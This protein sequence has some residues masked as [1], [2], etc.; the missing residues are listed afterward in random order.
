MI[1][2]YRCRYL[3]ARL[4]KRPLNSSDPAKGCYYSI[5]RL[6]KGASLAKDLVKITGSINARFIKVQIPHTNTSH[7]VFTSQISSPLS[8]RLPF[9][10]PHPSE[11]RGV[12]GELILSDLSAT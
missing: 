7:R 9:L 2:R 3:T 1:K 8:L 10:N 4:C 6:T 11:P 5:P 12:T